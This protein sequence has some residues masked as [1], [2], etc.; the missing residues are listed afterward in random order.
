[1][2]Q[3]EHGILTTLV[4]ASR[5]IDGHTTLHLQCG[6]VVPNLREVAMR[7]LVHTIQITLVALLVADD[8]DI[9]KRNDVAIHVDVSRILHT[10]HTI[11]IKGIAVHLRSEFVGGV[12]PHAILSLLQLSH[13]RGIVLTI[14]L[15]LDGLSGQEITCYLD[16]PP[17]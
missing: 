11:N 1:M 17:W 4:I 3:V 2:Q 14:T 12:A 5:G 6:T 7:H 13:T 10:R 16:F 8:E 9:G 15:D